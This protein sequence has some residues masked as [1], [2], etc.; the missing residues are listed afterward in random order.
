MLNDMDQHTLV[1]RFIE[2]TC[3]LAGITMHPFGSD[4]PHWSFHDNG[5]DLFLCIRKCDLRTEDSP[6]VFKIRIRDGYENMEHLIKKKAK[7]A[8]L[9]EVV[10]RDSGLPFANYNLN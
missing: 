3:H 9:M 6:Y 1:S 10:F 2:A 4:W 7:L 5:N 8:A